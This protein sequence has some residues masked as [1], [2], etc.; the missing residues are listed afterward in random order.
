VLAS[1]GHNAGI[2]SEPGKPRQSHQI[3]TWRSG[4]PHMEASEWQAR[5]PVTK[6]SWWPSWQAWLAARSTPGATPPPMGAPEKALPPLC[7][8]PGSY[9]LQR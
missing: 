8:A 6:G 4:E 1:G 5:T 7:D 2:V 9:V 3:A